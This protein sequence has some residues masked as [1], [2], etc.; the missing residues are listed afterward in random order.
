MIEEESH[1]RPSREV[2]MEIAGVARR[3]PAN[4]LEPK[5]SP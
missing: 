2:R 1:R 4:F 5:G 3:G